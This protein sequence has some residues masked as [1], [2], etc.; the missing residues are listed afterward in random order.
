[1]TLETPSSI[2]FLLVADVLA[3]LVQF[4]SDGGDR[5]AT[6][7]EVLAREILFAATQS[8]HGD[9]ALPL[10]EP[11]DR[12]HRVLRRNRNAHVHMV[13]LQMSFED[14]AFLLPARA[15]KISPS[16]WRTFPN[17]TF[18]RRLGMKTTWYLQS[19]FE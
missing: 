5:V 2:R 16:C 12:G 6:G 19:H 18:R 13:R 3:D 14:L 9:R 4:E 15:W 8:S 17:T 11:D 1:M 10:Q 7:P